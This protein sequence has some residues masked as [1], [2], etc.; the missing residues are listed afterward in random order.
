MNDFFFENDFPDHV[1][2]VFYNGKTYSR[3]SFG[4]AKDKFEIKRAKQRELKRMSNVS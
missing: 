2:S 1:S 3:E 4:K